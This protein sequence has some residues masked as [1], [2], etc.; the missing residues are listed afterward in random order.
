M[1]TYVYRR[2]DGSTFEIKQRITE[3]PLKTC[4]ET[5]QS[6]SRVIT[7]NT[8]LIF[9]GDGFYVNDYGNGTSASSEPETSSTPASSDAASSETSS[10]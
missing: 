1:P 8:G 4:P 2:E 6:V 5:G 7:G 3:D 9:N 10:S